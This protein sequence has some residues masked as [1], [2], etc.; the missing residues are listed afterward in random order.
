[1]ARWPDDLAELT[2]AGPTAAIKVFQVDARAMG[3]VRPESA[4]GRFSTEMDG[5]R[6][7]SQ[8]EDRGALARSGQIR[9]AGESR[10]AWRILGRPA[11]GMLNE[12]APGAAVERAVS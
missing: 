11:N 12:A 1:M 3:Q 5:S 9:H 8:T 6:G 4:V 7:S 10:I 2:T